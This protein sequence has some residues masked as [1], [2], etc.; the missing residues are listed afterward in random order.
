M[1]QLPIEPV[2]TQCFHY[3]PVNVPTN[4]T[5]LS[6]RRPDGTY[7]EPDG[8]IDSSGT[9]TSTRYGYFITFEAENLQPNLPVLDGNG[10][11]AIGGT[12]TKRYCI[13]GPAL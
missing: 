4:A 9:V 12:Y 1:S 5:V 10:T 2:S 11:S 6:C 3:M 7:I 8:T 13:L